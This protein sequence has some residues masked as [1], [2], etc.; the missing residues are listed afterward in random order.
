M[1]IV[2]ALFFICLSTLSC[3]QTPCKIEERSKSSTQSAEDIKNQLTKGSVLNRVKVYKPDGT[4]QCN[5]GKKISV[6]TMSK[7]LQGFKIYSS[8]N[9]HDGL[10][11]I[12]LCGKPTGQVNIFEIDLENL[13]KAE[14]LGFKKWSKE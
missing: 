2:I 4:L 10:M 9:K 11:R 12:Q 13:P 14:A 8:E 7:E 5:Q 3:Q 6:E 1:K